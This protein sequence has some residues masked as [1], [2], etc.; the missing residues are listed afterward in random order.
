MGS[1]FFISRQQKRKV[2]E[3]SRIINAGAIFIVQLSAIS[4]Q[5]LANDRERSAHSPGVP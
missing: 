3:K 5:Q 1:F 2:C 4:R